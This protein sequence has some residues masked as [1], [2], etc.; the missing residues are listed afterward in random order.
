[1][2][3]P[4]KYYVK[5]C[6][7]ILLIMA[8]ITGCKKYVEVEPPITSS[9]NK[10]IYSTDA[11]AT[12]V[13]T[14]LYISLSESSIRST[15][16]L[17]SVSLFAGLSADE[18]SLLP[19]VGD[20]A[21]VA[22]YTNSLSNSVGGLPNYWSKAYNMIYVCNSAIEGLSESKTLIPKVKNELLGEAHFMRAFLYFYLSNLYGDIPLNLTTD[23]KAN[24]VRS[25]SDRKT[26]NAQIISDLTEAK[27]LLSNEYRTYKHEVSLERVR[28][29]KF[30]AIAMLA[31]VYLYSGDYS[32]AESEASAIIENPMYRI[33][34][35]DETFTANSDETIWAIKP[36]RDFGVTNTSEAD[37]F[38]PNEVD[39]NFPVDNFP[40]HL[41]PQFLS[42]FS[43]DD[44]RYVKWTSEITLGSTPYRYVTKY[45]NDSPDSEVTEYPIV[46]RLAE[47]FLI[48]AECRAQRGALNGVNSAE[49]DLNVI[50]TRAGLGN[51]EFVPDKQLLLNEILNERQRELF[52]EWGHRWLDLKR[53]G[54]ADQVLGIVKGTY[55]QPSDQ[56]YLIPQ[57]ELDRNPNIGSN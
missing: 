40:V 9:T 47:Q 46:L 28:P 7:P 31:R 25:R 3:L 12:S 53:T 11:D 1:M 54:R 4:L 56:Y 45:K 19:G 14:N 34:D 13:L 55:W 41:N 43:T 42:H 39:L 37:F 51:L 21:F 2:N 8:A 29:N 35:I 18:L 23:Y 17:T 26:I 44:K 32:A 49:S 20:Q 22:H 5:N 38:I 10:L 50:R 15:D 16:N 6:I 57:E 52:T 30:A 24:S 27:K 48:R 36:V 33:T